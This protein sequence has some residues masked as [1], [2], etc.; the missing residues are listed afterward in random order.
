MN[1]LG[2]VN[3]THLKDLSLH[4]P[5]HVLCSV[6]YHESI[7]PVTYELYALFTNGETRF[8]DKEG[9]SLCLT[10][11][12]RNVKP[13]LRSLDS[14]TN[15]EFIRFREVMKGCAYAYGPNNRVYELKTLTLEARE[16]LLENH[17]DI[18]GMIPDDFAVEVTPENNPY[19][20][21]KHYGKS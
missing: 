6:Q 4:L 7:E 20:N 12:I 15:V 8:L 18:T 10:N 19:K 1:E 5:Y 11:T 13:Y 3:Q 17:F 9:S 14:M 16:W 2:I 21:Y